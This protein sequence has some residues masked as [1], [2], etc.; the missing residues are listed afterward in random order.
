MITGALLALSTP[1]PDLLVTGDGRHLA[2][3]TATGE[4]AIPR[5]RAGDSVRDML[6]ETSGT[7]SEVAPLDAARHAAS[8][9][10]LCAAETGRDGASWRVLATRTRQLAE[11]REMVRVCAGADI[12]VSDRLLRGC[13][14]RWLGG[15][16]IPGA[17]RAARVILGPARW[18]AQ[19]RSR[20]AATPWRERY[21]SASAPG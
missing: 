8:S 9:T 21:A 3:R 15:P 18:C 6:S 5:G 13:T 2:V 1:A 17:N 7:G 12:V 19:W 14:L 16:A 20:A 4:V 11:W 10:D